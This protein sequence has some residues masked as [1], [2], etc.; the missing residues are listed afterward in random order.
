MK[1][2]SSSTYDMAVEFKNGKWQIEI[3]SG[4]VV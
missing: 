4:T 2:G 3:I 1:W